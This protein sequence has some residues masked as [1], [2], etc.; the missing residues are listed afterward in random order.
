MATFWPH[1][2]RIELHFG[3]T[4]GTFGQGFNTQCQHGN[5]AR[6]GFCNNVPEQACQTADG[7][8]ADGVIGF[9]LVGQVNF[10][11]SLDAF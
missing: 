10:A 1:F 7:D 6:W 3:H 8:D 2:G 5:A 9:G 4:E 11:I